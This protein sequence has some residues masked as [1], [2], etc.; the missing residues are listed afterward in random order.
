MLKR[1]QRTVS[2]SG[3]AARSNRLAN[4]SWQ[5]ASRY[6]AMAT[7]IVLDGS[8]VYGGRVSGTCRAA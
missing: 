6:D 8:S 3:K 1:K 7:K 5:R 2:L 4:V